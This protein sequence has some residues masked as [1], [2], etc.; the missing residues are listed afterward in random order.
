M[1][2]LSCKRKAI[3]SGFC[4]EH[5]VKYFERK[6][7]KQL[8]L[9][10]LINRNEE[11]N[12]VGDNKELAKFMLEQLGRKLDAK[13]SK[14]GKTIETFA[15]DTKVSKDLSNLF[16]N[17]ELIKSTSIFEQFMQKELNDYAKIKGLK[18][19]KAKLNTI[20]KEINSGLNKLKKRKTN[21]FFGASNFIKSFFK[22]KG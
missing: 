15:L 8:A 3:Y 20:E 13:F 6:F 17:N 1:N 7:K 22:N 11:L 19:S 9:S 16:K 2:C 5:F 12:V 4:N 18:I 14:N 10:K 21:L